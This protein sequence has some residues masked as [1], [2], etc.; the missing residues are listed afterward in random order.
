[1]RHRP[2]I[3][4][5]CLAGLIPIAVAAAAAGTAQNSSTTA[6]QSPRSQPQATFLACF[7]Q[8]VEIYSVIWLLHELLPSVVTLGYCCAFSSSAPLRYRLNGPTVLAATVALY[9]GLAA[10]GW[11]DPLFLADNFLTIWAAAA[12][13]GTALSVVVVV[14]RAGAEDPAAVARAGFLREER[15]LRCL[16]TDMVAARRRQQQQKQQSLQQT[17]AAAEK[18]S[19]PPGGGEVPPLDRAYPRPLLVDFWNGRVFN[20]RVR[21]LRAIEP[22]DLKMWLYLAGAVLLELNVLSLALAHNGAAGADPRRWSAASLVYVALQSWFVSEYL[23]FERVHLYTYDLFA[24][25]V[26]F[27]LVF[28]CLGFYPFA[29]SLGAYALARSPF[30]SHA[31]GGVAAADVSPAAAAATVALYFAGWVLTRGANLQKYFYKVDPRA[32][33][34]FGGLVKQQT[35]RPGVPLLVSGFW[36]I[37][38]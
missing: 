15:Y 18:A 22:V 32:T 9:A 36:G 21:A 35:I 4:A 30:G 3:V 20:P 16:T 24:E 23:Y 8:V 33:S 5:L 28:G 11:K 17:S 34:C 29:Y 26:G 1:M 10:V 12:L 27:K 31:V 19:S 13:L 7:A 38:R 25:K 37:A 2:P 14:S 6:A